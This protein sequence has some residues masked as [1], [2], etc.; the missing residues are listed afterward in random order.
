MMRKASNVCLA[1][2]HELGSDI[3]LRLVG[4][5]TGMTDTT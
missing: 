4:E 5:G 3:E 1:L 2:H